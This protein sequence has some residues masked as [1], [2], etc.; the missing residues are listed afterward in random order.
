LIESGIILGDEQPLGGDQQVFYPDYSSIQPIE[1][2]VEK[3]MMEDIHRTCVI[4]I[5]VLKKHSSFL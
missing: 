4:L 3:I 2:F 1:D 5:L